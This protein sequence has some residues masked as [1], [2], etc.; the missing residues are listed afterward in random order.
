MR[1]RRLWCVLRGGHQLNRRGFACERC[2][3]YWFEFLWWPSTGHRAA[4][5]L[6]SIPDSFAATADDHDND[7]F[8]MDQMQHDMEYGDK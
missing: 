4:D 1:L 3:T 8:G 7:P 6:P 2:R 5:G